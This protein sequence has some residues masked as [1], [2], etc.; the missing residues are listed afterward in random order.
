M[1][2]RMSGDGDR[3]AA[4]GDP[5]H[6]P[7][8]HPRPPGD[9]HPG[10]GGA[11]PDGR[12]PDA[13]RASSCHPSCSPTRR[14][15]SWCWACSP[16][17]AWGWRPRG[18]RSEGA[19]AKLDRVLPETL[20]DRLGAAQETLQLGLGTADGGTT[21]TRTARRCSPSAPPPATGPGSASATAPP[22]AR[23]RERLVDP[24]GI[25]FHGGRWY[26]AAWDHLREDDAHLPAGPA[27]RHRADPGELRAAGGIR[28][29]GADPPQHGEHPLPVEG[30]GAA[31]R[32]PRGGPPA[33]QPEPGHRRAAR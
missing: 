18:W 31:A 14:P 23:R 1:R 10:R 30:R 27:A 32:L 3:P 20:R 15:W 24:Y 12:L 26:V 19:L 6:R 16:W 33:G 8:L 28:P 2:R 7:P 21:G 13:P 9:G 25:A 22:A 11:W 5:A 17:S 4:R 29:L